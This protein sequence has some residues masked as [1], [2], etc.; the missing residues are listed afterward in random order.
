MQFR[1]MNCFIWERD[2]DFYDS[3]IEYHINNP[4]DGLLL[5]K[6]SDDCDSEVEIEY[7]LKD[8]DGDSYSEL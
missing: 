8:G 2:A 4:Q 3:I 1:Q 5:Y 7:I 6:R